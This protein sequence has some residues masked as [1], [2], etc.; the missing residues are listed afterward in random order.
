MKIK[1]LHLINK[2]AL[3]SP[4]RWML[5]LVIF[6][7]SCMAENKLTIS[8]IIAKDK[9]LLDEYN[10]VKYFSDS[11]SKKGSCIHALAKGKRSFNPKLTNTHFE[12]RLLQNHFTSIVD[13]GDTVKFEIEFFS[14]KCNC[15]CLEGDSV[16]Y[17]FLI[18]YSKVRKS[19]ISYQF[20]DD[21]VPRELNKHN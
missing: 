17:V 8:Q 4:I 3:K 11:I 5:G 10:E 18:F 7:F 19:I 12:T 6:N 1:V 13:L 20:G 9:G 14:K 21:W 16:G 2:L 15:S